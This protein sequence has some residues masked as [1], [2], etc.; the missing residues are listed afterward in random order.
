MRSWQF[1]PHRKWQLA[2]GLAG[3]Y[4]VAFCSLYPRLGPATAVL[5]VVPVTGAA[6]LFGAAA[7][8]LAWALAAPLLFTLHHLSGEPAWPTM[9][10]TYGLIGLGA[11]LAVSAT[12][13]LRQTRRQAALAVEDLDTLRRLAYAVP[14]VL[15]I[16]DIQR[17]RSLYLS[18]RTREALGYA[19][20][21]IER[22]P[23]AFLKQALDADDWQAFASLCEQLERLPEN[24]A[25]T[26]ECRLKHQDGSWRWFTLRQVVLDR[27]PDSKPRRVLG[28]A[29]DM[30][31][32]RQAELALREREKLEVSLAKEQELS[33]LKNR[34][35]ASLSHEFRT[36]L[37][38]ILASSELLERYFER[39]PPSRRVEAFATIRS[40]VL[41]LK[42]ML[43]ELSDVVLFEAHE[44]ACHPHPVDLPALCRDAIEQIETMEAGARITLT[45]DG[46]LAAVPLDAEL[47]KPVVRVLLHNAV[48]YSPPGSGVQIALARRE[49]EVEIR[50]SDQ[51]IGISPA[52]QER[53]FEPLFRGGNVGVING[54]GLGLTLARQ[55]VGLHGGQ[56]AVASQVGQ[57]STFTVRLP[58][59]G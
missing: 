35:M 53:I 32:S 22:D 10:A 50:V 55:Y 14:D 46:D 34:M 21:D 56:I 45:A 57:G 7:G 11:L 33:A 12:G 48:K 16:Y 6:L 13:I 39:L 51:G 30:T 29:H 42:A 18:P 37:A 28:L 38:S 31:A 27:S 17:E 40:Q 44:R 54:L 43:D 3:L 15:F 59:A 25:L 1:A 20:S 19:P 58:I 8:I 26:L 47:V 41:R 36:P 24:E 9:I 5:V 23:Q 2:L 49:A 52:D 4:L